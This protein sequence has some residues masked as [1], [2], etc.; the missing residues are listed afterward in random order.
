MYPLDEGSAVK[1]LIRPPWDDVFELPVTIVPGTP[2][3]ERWR[4]LQLIMIRSVHAS[5]STFWS[6]VATRAC[7]S[8]TATRAAATSCGSTH[9]GLH[10][11]HNDGRGRL[12]ERARLRAARPGASSRSS[13]MSTAPGG[14]MWNVRCP[15]DGRD[16]GIGGGWPCLFPM[17]PF[18]GIDVGIDR[19]SPVSWD[20]YQQHGPY[21]YPG[22]SRG[23]VPARRPGARRSGEPRTPAHD[24]ARVR[25]AGSARAP[26]GSARRF[27]P[28]EPPRRGHCR[29]SVGRPRRDAG[30]RRPRR[31]VGPRRSA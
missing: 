13:S 25:V 22:P 14:N 8:P 2:T 1:F 7:S 30:P 24:G 19:R 11:A 26:E 20:L 17:A 6:T 18:E 28:V 31:S 21:P 23:R 3:L 15:V 29:R 16:S 10:V 27:A 12:R 5:R 9:D 4:S